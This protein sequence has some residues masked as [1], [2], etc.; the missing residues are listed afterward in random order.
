[1]RHTARLLVTAA[2]AA[3]VLLLGPAATAPAS[4]EDPQP[5]IVG[6][7]PATQ[8]YRGVGSL[9]VQ[10]GT[11]PSF[12]T[13]AVTLWTPRHAITNAHCVTTTDGLPKDPARYTIQWDAID[14]LA[15]DPVTGVTK[16]V[17]HQDWDWLTPGGGLHGDIAVLWLNTP[18]WSVPSALPP[19]GHSPAP[20]AGQQARIVGWGYTSSPPADP[21][22]P[23]YMS[24]ADLRIV[25]PAACTAADIDAGEV[26]VADP[27]RPGVAA[28]NG[29]SGGPVMT[30][31][32][33]SKT[34]WHLAGTASRETA[35][36]CTGPV[37]Y[38]SAV[39]YRTWINDTIAGRGAAVPRPGRTLA[40]G[41]SA[42][43]WMGCGITC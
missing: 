23:R 30:P 5:L 27:A 6:G 20:P 28:C 10:R 21:T 42:Y 34:I 25:D 36:G 35:A 43:R 4:A 33:T 41:S 40:P 26:C 1:M 3:A 18:V 22:A 39:Y 11:D 7:R 13:C 17:A 14:R 16:I 31:T 9:Q 8:V 24:E 15:G 2:M 29:D 32:K 12:H 19:V 37:V 38:T